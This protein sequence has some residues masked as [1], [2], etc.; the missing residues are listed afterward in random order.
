MTTHRL[1]LAKDVDEIYFRHE[2]IKVIHDKNEVVGDVT[3]EGVVIL[4]PGTVVSLNISLGPLILFI[5]DNDFT[6]EEVYVRPLGMDVF[7]PITGELF[8]F[9]GNFAIVCRRNSLVSGQRRAG[10][11]M[12]KDEADIIEDVLVGL[13]NWID[14]LYGSIGDEATLN[15]AKKCQHLFRECFLFERISQVCTDGFRQALLELARNKKVESCDN[16]PM[17][18]F[19]VQGDE[20]YHDDMQHHIRLA[21]A[22]HHTAMTCQV[23]TFVMHKSQENGWDWTKPIDKRFTHYIWDFGEFIGWKDRPWIYYSQDEHMRATPHGIWPARWSPARPIRKHYPFRSPEQAKI[24]IADRLTS[25]WQPHYKNYVDIFMEE[26][27]ANRPIKI[28][29]GW[30]PEVERTEGIW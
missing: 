12:A 21:E 5:E 4:A 18:V 25:G 27:V 14:Y 7:V 1:T 11:L 3:F 23:A 8:S 2:A 10:I 9:R 22:G 28:F 17:W 16:R 30:F 20:I 13:S 29:H 15:V 6:V 26:Q 24:R 19:A